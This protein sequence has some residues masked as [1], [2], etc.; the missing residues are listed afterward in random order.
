MRM[1]R[2][3]NRGGGMVKER[4]SIGAICKGRRR[5]MVLQGRRRRM[6]LRGRRRGMVL[7]GRRRGMVLQGRRRIVLQGS[8]GTNGRRGK[9]VKGVGEVEF[10]KRRSRRTSSTQISLQ[11]S[12]KMKTI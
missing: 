9:G 12:Q 3:M 8:R 2:I 5:G 10:G 1:G 11:T 7:Q 6:V 4:G